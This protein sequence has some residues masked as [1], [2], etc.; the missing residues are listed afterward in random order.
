[1][2][3]EA[4]KTKLLASLT[5]AVETWIEESAAGMTC[6]DQVGWCGPNLSSQMA[7]AAMLILENN[8]EASATAIE[9]S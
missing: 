6:W 4:D 7:R 3:N 2:M 8:A 9:N 5:D 1:M